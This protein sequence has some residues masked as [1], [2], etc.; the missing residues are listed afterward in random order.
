MASERI[1]SSNRGFD[2]ISSSSKLGKD[3]VENIGNGGPPPPTLRSKESEQ[4]ILNR[5]Q[6]AG[7]LFTQTQ[8]N[9]IATPLLQTSAPVE[10]A[11]PISNET[12]FRPVP[13]CVYFPDNDGRMTSQNF[14]NVS[15]L[16]QLR[17]EIKQ[18]CGIEGE[19]SLVGAGRKINDTSQFHEVWH[20]CDGR[21]YMVVSK[22]T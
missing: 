6:A 11:E 9:F 14:Y 13:V 21:F 12:S 16:N 5:Q 17:S 22:K 4:K 18:R 10:S 7:S 2:P 19:F 8:A 3:A 15:D 20:L 1:S